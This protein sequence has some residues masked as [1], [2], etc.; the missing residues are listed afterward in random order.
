MD[1]AETYVPR[2]VGWSRTPPKQQFPTLPAT[3]MTVSDVSSI[4]AIT[5][6]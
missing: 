6:R 4:D 2:L 1:A 5:T 3:V